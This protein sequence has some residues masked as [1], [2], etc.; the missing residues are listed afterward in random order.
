MFHSIYLGLTLDRCQRCGRTCHRASKNQGPFPVH[1]CVYI[2]NAYVDYNTKIIGNVYV[3][4]NTKIDKGQS[5]ST[6]SM[7]ASLSSITWL[8]VVA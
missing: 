4:Y 5:P 8:L 2:G 7:Q 1:T 6:Y 3:D